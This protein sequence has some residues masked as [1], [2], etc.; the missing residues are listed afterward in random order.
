M[1]MSRRGFLQ[2]LAAA[3][4]ATAVGLPR[5]APSAAG[6]ALPGVV[7][8]DMATA[9]DIT[10]ATLYT[11]KFEVLS[12]SLS[13]GSPVCIELTSLGDMQTHYRPPSCAHL[14]AT[15]VM[16]DQERKW[17]MEALASGESV[18]LDINQFFNRQRLLMPRGAAPP[19]PMR[20]EPSKWYVREVQVSAPPD[21]LM[22]CHVSMYNDNAGALRASA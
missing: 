8:V 2:A 22:V 21:G 20:F 1:R 6:A 3:L 7:G 5:G 12:A 13:F 17:L 4:G 19:P 15:V 10:V 14:D 11:P 18:E 9:A 16:Q